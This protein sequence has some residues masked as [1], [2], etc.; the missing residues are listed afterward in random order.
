[1]EIAGQQTTPY[2]MTEVALAPIIETAAESRPVED[3]EAVSAA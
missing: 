1:V 2:Q 3:R